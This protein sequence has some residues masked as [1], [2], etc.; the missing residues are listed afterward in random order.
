MTQVRDQLETARKRLLDMSLRNKLL[1]FKTYRKSTV[2]V[3]DEVPAEVYRRLVFDEGSLR[4]LPASDHPDHR[5]LE[6]V[7]AKE[8]VLVRDGGTHVCLHCEGEASWFGNRGAFLDHLE[9]DHGATLDGDAYETPLDRMTNVWEIPETDSGDGR[10]DDD[11][12]QTPH[13]ESNLQQRLFNI[14]NRAEALIEDAGYNALHLAIGFLEWSEPDS[15]GDANRAPLVLVPVSID[16]DGAQAAFE[17]SW[18]GAEVTGNRSLE[19]KLSDLGFSLPEFDRPESK[20][21]VKA[22]LRAVEAEADAI[23]DWQVLPDIHLGFF[24]YTKFVMYEDLDPERWSP[25]RSPVDHDLVRALLDPDESTTEPAPFDAADIDEALSPEDIHHVMDADPSQIAAI[26]DVKRGRNMV[27]EGPPGTGKSQTI[28]NMI[29][30]LMADGKTV[31]FVSEKLAALEVVKERLDAV[32]LGD[33]ALE[34]H[35]D[36]ASKADFL[37]EL[38]R[39]ANV[40]DF[41]ADNPTETFTRLA[42]RRAELNEYV[43]ALAGPYGALGRKPFELFGTVADAHNHFERAGVDFPRTHIESP[44]HVTTDHE[45]EALSVLR[46]LASQLEVVAPVQDHPW[47]GCHP[48]QILP[49]K[50]DAIETQ[51]EKATERF[52]QIR[53]T[54][55]ALADEYPL[56]E[57]KTLADVFR[58]VEAG[59]T[60]TDGYAVEPALFRSDRWN[61]R[62]AQADDLLE[63]LE[64]VQEL[65]AD[66]GSRTNT[67]AIDRDVEEV[68]EEYRTRRESAGRLVRPDWYRVKRQLAALYEGDRP[69]EATQIERDL[70]D[71]LELEAKR[72]DL[73]DARPDARALFSVLWDGPDTD[74]DELEAFA[75]WIVRF[76][77]CLVAETVTDEAIESVSAGVLDGSDL[78]DR[79]TTLE[80]HIREFKSTYR[81]LAE[82]VGADPEPLYGGHIDEAP[83]EAVEETLSRWHTSITAIDEW[84][85]FDRT[86][87]EARETIAEPL[88]EYVDAGRLAPEDVIPAFE[89]VLADSLLVSAFQNRPAL[90][91]FDRAIHE[92]RIEHFQELDR[93]SLQYNQQRVLERLVDQ[94]PKLM[95]GAS[96]SSQAGILLHEF[97]KE[98]MHKPIRI[99]L[100]ETGELIQQF[101]P[102]FMM[103]PLSV[104]KYL[105]PDTIEFDVVIFDEAS[106]V[107]PED[108]LGAILRGSQ[109]VL[110]GDR[111]QLP[112]TSFFDTIVD[113]RE[114]DEQWEFN[115]QDVESVL[116]LARSTFPAKRLKWHYRSRHES[117]IAVSNQEFYDNDL[118]IYPSPIQDADEL[119]LTL[120]HIPDT[121]YDRGNTS[122]NREEARAVA[123]AAIEHYRQN[124]E[125]S[126][127]IGTFSQAQQEAIQEELEGL[128]REHPE[129]DEYFSRERDEHCFVKNL[130]R[131]QGD[132]RD[133]IFISVGYGYDADGTFSHNFGPL[134]NSGGWRRLNV[135]ITRAREQ[136][137]VFSN[138]TADAI[139][140]DATD[141]RGVESLKVFLQY[142]E[143]RNLQSLVDVGDDPDSAFERAVFEFLRTEGYDVDPQVGCAGFRVDMAIPHPDDPERYVLGILCDGETYHSTPVARARD[144]QREAV[145]TDRGW[146][147]HRVWSTDWYRSR[148]TARRRLVDAVETAIEE[149]PSP[150]EDSTVSQPTRLWTPEAG[151]ESEQPSVADLQDEDGGPSLE[152]LAEPYIA[153]REIPEVD[154]GEYDVAGTADAVAAIVEAEGPIHR[155]LLERRLVDNSNVERR[156]PKIKETIETA[157]T[158]AL[159]RGSIEGDGQFYYPP[160]QPEVPVRR[161]NGDAANIEWI[162]EAEIETAVERILENQYGTARADLVSQ[163]ATVLGFERTGER[164]SERIGDVIDRM[165]EEGRVD[166][167]DDRLVIG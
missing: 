101:T 134:S 160:N 14:N 54:A 32:N 112:P 17:V 107:R 129:V 109:V 44:E 13:A 20:A 154:L 35:S 118:R 27:I 88:V 150:N 132:E 23:D 47:R 116:D 79:L 86:R 100:A 63:L 65:E 41:S 113:H 22:Y 143:N 157:I 74:R 135:L 95:D 8:A 6:T 123:E 130:E 30:E 80:D 50:R 149:A 31:L 15:S 45:Q 38:E 91:R 103:S 119:G 142:A 104:A 165:H 24:D 40:G 108:A 94:T 16:R 127:G 81:P 121:V 3:V 166:R 19:L 82:T 52:Q 70:E 128:R 36:R 152:D 98:R 73:E 11:T 122:V 99:L 60:L 144:R 33:F 120:E 59:E 4:F 141:S 9:T 77:S 58:L 148:E 117:L 146:R 145:L 147:I 39:I 10:H 131:I 29:A 71:L 167:S 48:G 37:H 125:A 153:A 46:S 53:L 140:V 139:D 114:S 64:R 102:C 97:G 156:G 93:E 163:T 159:R 161:R 51:V 57:P 124:P 133:V 5:E 56:S 68:L 62:P 75:D 164:I 61:A 66:V 158:N 83:L 25:G 115:V 72:A 96:K 18:T 2:T 1:N 67:D 78:A 136:C 151:A 7:P 90:A 87:A 34:L 111:K 55:M 89:G 155:E 105:D 26:E 69:S 42:Q 21:D 110:F 162:P 126:L 12:L 138:F 76:R 49:H 106:Q 28:V 92:D 84:A 137:V 85:R 43:T